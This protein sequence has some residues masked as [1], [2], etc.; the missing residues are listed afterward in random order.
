VTSSVGEIDYAL[1]GEGDYE[2]RSAM[3]C[4]FAGCNLR[5][6]YVLEELDLLVDSAGKRLTPRPESPNRPLSK[7]E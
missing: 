6:R 3:V 7:L 1:Q 2:G 5:S 4:G